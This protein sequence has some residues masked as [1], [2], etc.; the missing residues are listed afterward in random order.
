MSDARILLYDIES[1]PNLAY[2]WAKYDQNVLAYEE[3]WYLLSFAWKWLGD[4]KVNVLG[5]DDFPA[6]FAKDPKNDYRLVV[7]LH[8]LF[9]EA[10]V[11]VGHN[12]R[13]FDDKKTRARMLVHGFS[14]PRP[15]QQVDTCLVARKY[16]SFNSNSLKDLAVTLGL[17]VR[18]ADPGGIQ[19]W[20][21]CMA[22]NPKAWKTMKKYNKQDVT[23][24]EEIYLRMR[25][26]IE[27]HPNLSL[28]DGVIEECPNCGADE[29]TRQGFKKT[30]TQTFQQ[31]KCGACGSWSRSRL[32]EKDQPKP[33]FVN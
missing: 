4:T 1:A 13:S 15:F 28:L 18:K 31:W 30:R 32:A 17:P 21:N 5:L 23:V 22:G 25:P 7:K 29:M 16:F 26:W 24:L 14:P 8:E 10:D 6:E 11:V 27:G 9:S 33:L 3:E 12:S 20:L 19:T 2:V